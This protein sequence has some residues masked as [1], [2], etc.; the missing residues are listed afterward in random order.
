MPGNIRSCPS[1]GKRSSVLDS[2]EKGESVWRRR[3]CFA[4]GRRWSTREIY[5][6]DLKVVNNKG[7]IKGHLRVILALLERKEEIGDAD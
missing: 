5:E 1:C 7:K 6:E 4:C 3:M 2:R